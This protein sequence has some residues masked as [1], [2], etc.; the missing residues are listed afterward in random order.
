M[1]KIAGTTYFKIDGQ[2]LSVTGGIEV[3]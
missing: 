3:P 2:Q 1:G